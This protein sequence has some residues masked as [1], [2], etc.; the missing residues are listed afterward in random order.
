[1]GTGHLHQYDMDLEHQAQ[2]VAGNPV[3]MRSAPQRFGRIPGL[4]GVHVVRRLDHFDFKNPRPFLASNIYNVSRSRVRATYE[5]VKSRQPYNTLLGNI[6]GRPLD[7]F[8]NR[9][10]LY[11]DLKSADSAYMKAYTVIDKD[12]EGKDLTPHKR[13]VDGIAVETSPL[14][15]RQEMLASY[16]DCTP[17]EITQRFEFTHTDIRAFVDAHELQHARSYQLWAD[18]FDSFKQDETPQVVKDN[19]AYAKLC[20]K[21]AAAKN[22]NDKYIIYLQEDMSDTVAVLHHLKAGRPIDMVQA[23]ADARAIGHLRTPA[24]E[25]ASFTVL[26]KIIEDEANVRARLMGADMDDIESMA[27]RLVG[28]YSMDRDTF[29]ANSIAIGQQMVND[30]LARGDEDDIDYGT[31]IVEKYLREFPTEEHE[32]VLSLAEKRRKYL[33]ARQDWAM[34]NLSFGD[35]PLSLEEQKIEALAAIRHAQQMHPEFD[36]PRG[37]KYLLEARHRI[38]DASEEGPTEDHFVIADE[39]T[40]YFDRQTQQGATYNPSPSRQ[41]P[42]EIEHDRV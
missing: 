27:A 31:I 17:E 6:L 14:L 11:R 25:Y 9:R 3:F 36:T 41:V 15:T 40:D 29:Y 10:E 34:E 35:E 12:D 39:L 38:I 21:A 28:T 5:K 24:E 30:G 13:R 16:A 2:I 7:D 32:A 18:D 20:Q 33:E 37:A 8:K 23:I 26:D 4:E 19:P 22:K 1:M 42:G